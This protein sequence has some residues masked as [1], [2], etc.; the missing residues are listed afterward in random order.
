MDLAG[1]D[2]RVMKVM[3]LKTPDSGESERNRWENLAQL[4]DTDQIKFVI[5]SREDFEWARDILRDRKLDEI[6]EVLFSPSWGQQDPGK[7]ADWILEDGLPVRMQV[8]LHKI[9][10]GDKPGV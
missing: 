9:L 6:C 5:C 10:W 2:A 4:N 8:Q 7:L 1:V 3:D